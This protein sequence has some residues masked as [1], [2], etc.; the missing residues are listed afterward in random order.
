MYCIFKDDEYIYTFFVDHKSY[1]VIDIEEKARPAFSPRLSDVK[2]LDPFAHELMVKTSKSYDIGDVM[3]KINEDIKRDPNEEWVA[4]ILHLSDFNGKNCI[5]DNKGYK[6]FKID[7][8]EEIQGFDKSSAICHKAGLFDLYNKEGD[9][10]FLF[11]DG[12]YIYSFSVDRNSEISVLTTPGNKYYKL[13]EIKDIDSG[14]YTIIKT[15][16]STPDILRKMNG[17]IQEFWEWSKNS[18]G[19]DK[20]KVDSQNTMTNLNSQHGYGEEGQWVQT[21]DGDVFI[22]EISDNR[23]RGYDRDGKAKT[24]SIKDIIRTLIKKEVIRENKE[25]KKKRYGVVMLYFDDKSIFEEVQELIDDEDI[26]ENKDGYPKEGREKN[27][28]VTVL[29]GL[30]SD[31][32][33]ETIEDII[34][35][36]DQP[37]I[38][39]KNIGIFEDDSNKGYDVV[40][41][42]IENKDLN[43]MNRQLTELPYTSDYPDYH[44]HITI[45]FTTAGKGEKYVQSL[46]TPI[47][48]KPS[49]IVY[50]KANG[51]KKEYKFG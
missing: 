8:F 39:F 26:Y 45:A 51:T 33:D 15:F 30:H 17:P 47:K 2:V 19:M 44:P 4:P 6:L 38:S 23:Y 20:H 37:E 5:F 43:E 27:P 18:Y 48:M 32:S 35:T 22:E 31:V 14:A 25:I 12:I 13:E 46:D 34:K 21:Q 28:H 42:D 11:K 49:K 7:N 41:F 24:G 36:W 50:K 3:K 29:F 40:K 9:I 16:T 1:E 10:H